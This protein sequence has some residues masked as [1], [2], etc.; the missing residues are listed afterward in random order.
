MSQ[1]VQSMLICAKKEG[2]DVA[3]VLGVD[4][5]KE[6]ILG[7]NPTTDEIPG[8]RFC[9]GTG[10]LRYYLFNWEGPAME[11]HEIGFIAI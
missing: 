10:L 5:L 8:N 11:D 7:D 2:F 9:R 3:T 4:G 6:E 1:L